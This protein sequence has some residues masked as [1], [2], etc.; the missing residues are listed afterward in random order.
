MSLNTL[1]LV[2]ALT[3]FL[4]IWWGHVGV[5]KIEANS[6]KLWPPMTASIAL[7]VICETTAFRLSSLHLS[8]VFGIT[9]VVFLWDAFEFY[10]Q[11]KRVKRGHAPANPNN[12]RHARILADCPSASAFDWLDRSPRGSA[13]SPDEIEAIARGAK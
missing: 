13:Y 3:A 2:S 11:E 8:A 10:R 5:R 7:G 9:G 1:G 6:A 4:S 12:P